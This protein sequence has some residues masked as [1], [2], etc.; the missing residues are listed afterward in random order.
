MKVKFWLIGLMSWMLAG[1]GAHTRL[2]QHS[3][4]KSDSTRIEAHT[5]SAR[6]DSSFFKEEKKERILDGSSI[7]SVYTRA[8]LDSLF[9]GLRNLPSVSRTIYATDPKMR[10]MLSI[11]LDSL[12][13]IHLKCATAER[14]YYETTIRQ[15]RYM[16]STRKELI[17]KDRAIKQLEERVKQYEAAWYVKVWQFLKN[18]IWFILFMAGSIVIFITI[19]KRQ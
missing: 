16:E 2:V 12:G 4:E 3:I 19:R 14:T 18:G 11:V 15:G 13:R 9:A 8:E 10:T 17:E 7:E 1:C 6:S 5:E